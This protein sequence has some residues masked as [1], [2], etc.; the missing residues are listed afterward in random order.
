MNT[1]IPVKRVNHKLLKLRLEQTL[2]DA[3]VAR[4]LK[5]VMMVK[6]QLAQYKDVRHG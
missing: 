3:M 4:D 5:L 2:K 6:G 1:K